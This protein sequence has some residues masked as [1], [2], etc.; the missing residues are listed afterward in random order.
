MKEKSPDLQSSNSFST[1]IVNR[2][3]S[4][5]LVLE[6]GTMSLGSV[7]FFEEDF[8]L[9]PSL[10]KLINGWNDFR[11]KRDSGEKTEGIVIDIA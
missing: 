1:F 10:E 5:I 4:K 7:E 6:K 3:R 11:S 2:M 8:E 9:L